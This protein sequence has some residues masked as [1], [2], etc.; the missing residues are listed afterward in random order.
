MNY[1]FD[2]ESDSETVQQ[3]E[4]IQQPIVTLEYLLN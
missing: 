1:N 2:H 3:T 4:T